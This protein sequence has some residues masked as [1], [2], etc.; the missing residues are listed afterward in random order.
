M[1]PLEDITVALQPVTPV[2][3]FPVPNS[4]RLLD[5]TSPQGSSGNPPFSNLN[6]FT[7]AGVNTTN[8]VQNYGWEYVWHCHILGH[9]ENDMMRPIIFQVPPAA[10]GSLAAANIL[11]SPGQVILAWMDNSANETGFTIQRDVDPAFPN[12]VSITAGPS[13]GK[14]NSAN[15]GTDWGSI[16]TIN[17]NAGSGTFFYRV[18][19]VDNGWAGGMSQ[20]YNAAIL[21]SL[22][23]PW[24]NVAMVGTAANATVT[25]PS[26]S[27]G[28]VL[29]NKAGV[30]QTV[31]LSNASGAGTL[32]ISGVSITG[33]NSGDFVV[34]ASTC[35]A[36]LAAGASCTISV[37]FQ[38]TTIGSRIGALTIA[39]SNPTALTVPLTGTGI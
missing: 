20:T 36:S 16:Q 35:T 14:L 8:D 18:Q 1:N 6:P 29:V 15:E 12:P 17:D 22:S 13:T 23:S 30:P 26:L 32:A 34:S 10:P 24:S 21:G 25:P 4:V 11:N 31:I 38:P 5:V 7:N 19:A 9:E 39:S 27:F 37:T 33:V 3:P 2:P 28:S